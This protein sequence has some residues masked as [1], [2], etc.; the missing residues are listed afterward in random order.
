MLGKQYVRARSLRLHSC[1][2]FR[3]HRGRLERVTCAPVYFV[4]LG[5]AL[6]KLVHSAL[7]IHEA[8]E[9]PVS[10][11]VHIPLKLTF[12]VAFIRGGLSRHRQWN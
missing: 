6:G 3:L 1:Q 8:N 5:A 2:I 4:E 10:D 11:A 7:N 12:V 9:M